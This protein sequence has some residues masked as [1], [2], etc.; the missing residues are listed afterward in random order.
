MRTW[1]VLNGLFFLNISGPLV[2]LAP[3][4]S[5][6][7][8]LQPPERASERACIER[9]SVGRSVRAYKRGPTYQ[10]VSWLG[11]LVDSAAAAMLYVH[12]LARSH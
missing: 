10:S 4:P 12:S 3:D 11:P 8:P 2:L 7:P 5:N 6:F 9:P 1:K